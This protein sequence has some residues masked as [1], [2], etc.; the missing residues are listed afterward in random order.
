MISKWCQGVD[1]TCVLCKNEPETRDHLF[2]KCSYSVQLWRYLVSGILG[3]SYSDVWSEIVQKISGGAL[4]KR[5][6]FCLRYAFHAATYAIWTER[7]RVKHGEN[8]M[9]M[10]L[11][12]KL[13]EKGIRNKPSLVRMKGGKGMENALQ[14]WFQTRV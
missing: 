6:L 13:T 11:L 5:S 8:L 1:T 14:Y 7:N 3:N 12:T 2:F 4:D 10:A 9:S